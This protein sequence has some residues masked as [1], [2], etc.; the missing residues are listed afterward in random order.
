M[1]LVVELHGCELGVP[2][3]RTFSRRAAKRRSIARGPLPS[4]P[5]HVLIESMGLKVVR[6]GE[7]LAERHERNRRCA[8]PTC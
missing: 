3:L 2:D 7:W 1:L 8:T 5:L 4:G 6:A